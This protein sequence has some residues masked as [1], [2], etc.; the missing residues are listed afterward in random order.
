M[1]TCVLPRASSHDSSHSRTVEPDNIAEVEERAREFTKALGEVLAA[2]VTSEN[3]DKGSPWLFGKPTIIDAHA[4]A[5]VARLLDRDMTEMVPENVQAYGRHIVET[6]E[7]KKV[8]H[9]RRTVWDPSLG[10]VSVLN[11]L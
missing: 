11:P 10:D 9:G 7:W 6:K 5:M 2:T 4:T 1:L 8:T 3:A